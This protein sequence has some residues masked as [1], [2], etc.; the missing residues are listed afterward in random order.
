MGYLSCRADSSIATCRSASASAV[1][2]CQKPQIKK[3]LKERQISDLDPGGNLTHIRQ[4]DYQELESATGNFSDEALLGRGS[5]GT[6]YKAVLRCGRSVAV[7][8]P[9]RRHFH[10]S[11][12]SPPPAGAAAPTRNEVENEIE[13]L[14]GIRSSRLVNLIGFTP[15]TPDCKERLLVVEFMPNGTL[16]DLLH[17]N[18]HPPGWTRRLRLA[19]QTAKALNT[20]HSVQP[21][22]IH[23]DVKSANVL[24][25]QNFNARL[26]DFG[27]ALRDEDNA[28][29]PSSR[30]TPPAGTLGYLDPS[31]VTPENLSTK[32]DV[33]SFGI[34]LLEIMSGR[35][36]IDVA[37]S[38]PSVVEWAV[39]LLR[40]GMVATL[41]DPRIAPPKDP[42]A[43]KQLA[44]LA[45]SCVRSYKEMRPSMQEVVEQLKVLSKTVPSRAWNALSVGN[46]C[47]V[48]DVERT[49][50]KLNASS[51]NKDEILGSCSSILA[52]QEP[53][54]KDKDL[55][56]VV[57]KP[58]VFLKQSRSLRARDVLSEKTKGRIN[59]LDLMAQP[60]APLVKE[61]APSV[62]G[63]NSS[64]I[65]RARTLR[66]V[67]DFHETDAIFQ[68]RNRSMTTN[69]LRPFFSSNLSINPKNR[70]D[71]KAH[72][73]TKG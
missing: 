5:H 23:R 41:F 37:Y 2:T 59:L 57:K 17:S 11:S 65:S 56:V 45:T 3:G 1:T 39:P 60:N 34:L 14:C 21:P 72:D 43:R 61:L 33:F 13:I 20:L 36:A 25:D 73:Q 30:S 62:S 6:V 9:S 51:M 55:P 63:N 53:I 48:V 7:K 64:T 67:H 70:L 52:D 19:L 46:P 26:G 18:P 10:L 8:R 44:S 66:V 24:I 38:P 35:K 16:Y 12:P 4:F 27:L 42:V 58:P 29:F 68:L 31:Y 40:K 54:S 49:L 32:T 47:S 50:T 15:S 22:V 69:Q 71:E 28:K